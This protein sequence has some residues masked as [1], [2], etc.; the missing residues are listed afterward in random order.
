MTV[1]TGWSLSA[2]F[3]SLATKR[4]L[5]TRRPPTAAR[6]QR[7]FLIKKSRAYRGLVRANRPVVL[8]CIAVPVAEGPSAL[9]KNKGSTL[10]VDETRQLA[11]FCYVVLSSVPV[12]FYHLD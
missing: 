7:P 11:V 3:C 2:H 6:P 1:E 10:S 5:C 12:L 8:S 4:P 9:H